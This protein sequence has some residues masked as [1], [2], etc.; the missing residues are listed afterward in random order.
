MVAS[1][2][3]FYMRNNHTSKRPAHHLFFD[4]ESTLTPGDKGSTQHTVKL[5]WMCYWRTRDEDCEP[6]LTYIP[7]AT[8]E[9]FWTLVDA[10]CHKRTSL[11]LIAHNI[12]YDFG[13][14][15][16]FRTL[17]RWGFKLTKVYTKAMTT[18]LTWKNGS[19]TIKCLD[20]G[21]FFH[22]SLADLGESLGYPK[23]HVD[24]ATVSDADLSAYCHTDVEIMVKAWEALYT[25]LDTHDLGNWGQTLASQAMNAYRHRFMGTKILIKH[26]PDVIALERACYHGGRVSCFF[27][28]RAEKGPYY[29]LDIN[30]MFPHIMATYPMPYQIIGGVTHPTEEQLTALMEKRAVVADVSVTVPEP[31]FPINYHGHNVYPVGDLRLALTTPEISYL[32]A[33]GWHYHVHSATSYRTKIIFKEY[34]DFFYRL[35][36]EY[37]RTGNKPFYLLTKLYLNSLYGK[38]GQLST[39][40]ERVEDLPLEL[41]DCDRMYNTVTGKNTFLYHFG[42]DIWTSFAD[43]EGKYSFPAISAHVTAYSRLLLW[44]LCKQAGAGHFLYVDTDS[45]IVDPVGYEALADQIDPQALGKLKVEGVG[46]TVTIMVPKVYEFDSAWVR[47]GIPKS[48]TQVGPQSWEYE[49][50]TSLIGQA[51]AHSPKVYTSHRQTKTLTHRL[52][53]GVPQAD[54]AVRPTQVADLRISRILSDEEQDR[55]MRMEAE[56]E[57]VKDSLT[58]AQQTLFK[59]WNYTTDTFKRQRNKYGE[60]VAPEEARLDEMANESGYADANSFREN[61]A[62][63]IGDRRRYKALRTEHAALLQ[64]QYDAPTSRPDNTPIPF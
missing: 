11:Y 24:F 30:S 17:P 2:N 22:G 54:G 39:K 20:N 27:V 58:I 59:V 52:Y 1:P 37:K 35:K 47:K 44:D 18:I 4:V 42:D 16:G 53:D 34:V 9:E 49:Q 41:M 48:A 63:Q 60:L 12:A 14:L 29:K 26:D 10:H 38:F 32:Q 43:G 5:G 28:G 21:N 6:A 55:I 13:V 15:D 57:A 25:F 8:P 62:A 64:S 31:V 23:G 36:S 7:F 61:V 33:R 46:Q 56:I 45:L 50:F 3:G 19:R 40:W 51:H